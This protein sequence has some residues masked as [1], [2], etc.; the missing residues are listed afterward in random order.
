MDATFIEI[1]GERVAVESLAVSRACEL[2]AFLASD[3]YPYARVDSIFRSGD[4]REGVIADL[5]LEVGQ[6]PVNDV[7]PAE[8]VALLF[9][10]SDDSYP[11]VL[12][13]RADFP[14]VP[15]L[16]LREH[17]YPRSLCI[18]GEPYPV[19]RLT[20]TPVR[21]LERI[22]MWFRDTARGA[23]HRDDQPLEPILMPGARRL[24][25]PADLFSRANNDAPEQL[26][27]VPRYLS[28]PGELP[29]ETLIAR[30]TDNITR[31]ERQ[32]ALAYLATTFQCPA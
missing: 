14:Q 16:N 23:L 4:G 3:V 30:R 21:F 29:S 2:V 6:E 15:H 5:S 1:P 9:S 32:Q 28:P 12:S 26:W 10:S 19:V 7:R 25:V 31:Q 11:E 13:L 20:W 17:E 27:I 24:V 22:R 8:R 18:Y